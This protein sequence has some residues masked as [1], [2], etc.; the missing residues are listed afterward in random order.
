MSDAASILYGDQPS[1]NTP[2]PSSSSN[3]PSAAE[4]LYGDSAQQQPKQQTQQEAR[5]APEDVLYP[6]KPEQQGNPYALEKDATDTLYGGTDQVQLPDYLDVTGVMEDGF[7]ADTLRT[8]LGYMAAEAGASES[9]VTGLVASASEF[10]RSGQQVQSEEQR[11]QIL[12]EVMG[13]NGFTE[14]HLADA[15]DLVNSYPDYADWLAR[16]GA[17]DDPKIVSKMLKLSQTPRAQRRI[18]QFRNRSTRQ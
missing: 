1:G 12:A 7:E 17:G 8:N 5:Q 4:V 10:L 6:E 13:Q 11:G 9:D 15:R 16:T 18:Q 2:S 3:E 14:S